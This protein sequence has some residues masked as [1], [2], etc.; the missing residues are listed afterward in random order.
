MYIKDIKNNFILAQYLT[1]LS[2]IINI[3]KFIFSILYYMIHFFIH[4][5]VIRVNIDIL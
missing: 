2:Y 3:K 1:N 4:N 5:N